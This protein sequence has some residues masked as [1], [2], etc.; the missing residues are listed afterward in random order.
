MLAQHTNIMVSNNG[1]PEEPSMAINPINP[2]QMVVGANITKYC[3]SND[4][5]YNWNEGE[6]SSSF[7]VWGDPTIVV[8]TNGS[9]Y[10]FHLSGNYTD[11]NWLDRIVCQKSVNGGQTWSDGTFL[12]NF[13]PKQQDKQWSVVDPKTNAIY[14][15]WT[16]FDKYDSHVHTDSSNILFSKSTDGGLNWSVAKR[17]NQFAGDCLDGDSTVEG[18]FPAVGPNGE[19]YVSWAGPAGIRFDRSLDGGDTWLENDILINDMPGGWDMA[20]P[21]LNRSNGLPVINCDRSNS[22]NK[23]TIYVN[24]ADQRNGSFDTDIW[25]SKSTDGGNTWSVAKR[26]NDDPAGKQQFLSW[27]TIDQLNGNLYFVFYDRRNEVGNNNSTEVYMAV[28]KDGGEHFLN[29]KISESPFIPNPNIFFGDYN[30]IVAHNNIIRPIWTRLENDSISIW[31]AIIDTVFLGIDNLPEVNAPFSLDQ[32]YP[33]PFKMST[34]FAFKFRNPSIASLKIYDV[35]GKVVDILFENKHFDA[36]KYIE[37][38]DVASH[39]LEAGVYYFSLQNKAGV[40]VRK[41]IIE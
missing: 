2:L 20:I 38:F 14:I 23:G 18:A 19:L 8:D 39:N 4:G 22:V 29:F 15:T 6:L 11:S 32:N 5:G 10:F 12:G 35:F 34:S 26:V 7:G 9:F 27:M 25:L 3:Y 36:G 17:I 33:N 24:W 41:L 13:S 31:T 1:L 40:K 16:Q 28:S 37:N 21:G 30:N